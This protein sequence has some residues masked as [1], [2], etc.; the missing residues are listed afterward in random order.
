MSEIFVRLLR[1]K[2]HK[3]TKD[4]YFLQQFSIF[5]KYVLARIKYFLEHTFSKERYTLV[6]YE[7]R[8]LSHNLPR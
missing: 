4:K 1:F 6:R 2:L 8:L 3:R 7:T 5:I